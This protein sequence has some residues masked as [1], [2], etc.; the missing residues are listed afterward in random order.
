LLR[1]IATN[2][3]RLLKVGDVD[4]LAADSI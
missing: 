1:L 2:V 4:G 3:H